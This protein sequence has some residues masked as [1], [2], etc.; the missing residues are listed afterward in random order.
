MCVLDE[1]ERERERRVCVRGVR[2][3]EKG[4]EG[5]RDVCVSDERERE[6]TGCFFENDITPSSNNLTNSL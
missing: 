2:E 6:Y 3:R 5:E 4:R 1:R